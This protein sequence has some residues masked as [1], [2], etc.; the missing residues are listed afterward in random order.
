MSTS[1]PDDRLFTTR[2][3]HLHEQD[4]AA[5]EV[6][7][8][9]D[10][11]VPLSRRPRQRLELQPDGTA[12]VYHGGPDD[13]PTP[14]ASAL[15]GGR[16][17]PGRPDRDRERARC[18]SSSAARPGSSSGDRD[19]GIQSSR[20]GTGA[21]TRSATAF[22]GRHSS[23]P[24]SGIRTR[25]WS[26]LSGST[27][28]IRRCRIASAAWRPST[29]RTRS[30][31][32]GRSARCSGSS[33][34]ARRRR[35]SPPRWTSTI[36]TL[37]L[38]SGL[39][40]SPANGLFHLQMVYAVCSLT[41]AAFRKALG[42]GD[43]VGHDADRRRA[44]AAGGPAVRVRGQQR[45]LQ[46][47]GR[48]PVIRLLLGRRPRRRIH[49]ARRADRHRAQPR[50]RRARDHPRA[51]RRAALVVHGSV[52]RRRPGVPRGVLGSR[53]AVPALHLRRRGRARHPRVARRLRTRACC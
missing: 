30:W 46:P 31:N 35:W 17:S 3:V 7:A 49:A 18:G 9:E 2:W 50:H 15:V 16:R 20:P 1:N 41:Y 28:S 19:H 12:T 4:S 6:Y 37:L 44:A 42:R 22:R 14:T 33:V 51:A 43:R 38:S 48:R 23:G 34:T 26:G 8:P 40:P 39:S 5:G 52:E 29:C 11:P 45:G 24:I 32:A 27:R 47:R 53:R 21:P 36:P 10:G 25:P 13:R